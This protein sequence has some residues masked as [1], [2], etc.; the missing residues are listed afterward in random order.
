MLNPHEVTD[1]DSICGRSISEYMRMVEEF[2]GHL[3]PGL[4][5]GG[6]M[7][8]LALKNRPD[9]EF[10]DVICET[11]TCLPDAIQMLTPCT[12]G[13][14]WLKIV[15]TGRFALTVFDKYNGNGTRVSLSV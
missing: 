1:M 4:I 11:S 3:A 2:H 8:D 10:Y 12:Y 5:I 6:F 9:C 14:G 15:D 13:N 7:V